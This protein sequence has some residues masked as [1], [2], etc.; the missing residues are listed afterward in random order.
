MTD[1]IEDKIF[2]KMRQN[3]RGKIFFANDFD[4]IGN[5]KASSKALERLVN[6]EKIMRVSRGIYCI[7]KKTDFYGSVM[8]SHDDVVKAIVKRDNA[9]I[10]PTGL[11]AE[12]ILGLSTQVPMKVVYLTDGSPRKLKIG[13]QSVI[14]KKTSPKNLASKGKI[15]TLAI[16]AL[17]SIRKDRVTEDEKRKIIEVLKKENPQYLKHDI[18]YAP[19][20][21]REIMSKALINNEI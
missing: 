1:T 17:K 18:K 10:I 7:P 16:Q 9:K 20:W 4:S 2:M 6:Q 13:N 3:R 5:Y 11:F 21:I 19:L 12:N 15:S 8:L 14:F